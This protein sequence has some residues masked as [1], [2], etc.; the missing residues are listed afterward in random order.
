M[1]SLLCTCITVDSSST[2]KITLFLSFKINYSLYKYDFYPP[3]IMDISIIQGHTA[4]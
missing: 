2:H 3:N 4:S 1:H